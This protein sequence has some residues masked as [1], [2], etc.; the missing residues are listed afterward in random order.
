MV[1][2][3]QTSS[4]SHYFIYHTEL[5]TSVDKYTFPKYPIMIYFIE[6]NGFL[7]CATIYLTY[8]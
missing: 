4:K 7:K 2:K 8:F 5:V 6:V 3:D 1:K